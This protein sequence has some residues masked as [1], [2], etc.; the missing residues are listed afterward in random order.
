MKIISKIFFIVILLG[1]VCL[2]TTCS[3]E[4]WL[5][6]VTFKGYVYDSL[7]GKPVEGIWVG[8]RACESGDQ[9]NECQMYQVGQAKTDA[10]GYFYIHDNAARSNRY[11]PV[12]HDIILDGNVNTAGSALSTSYKYIYLN[13]I[14]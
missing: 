13:K 5:F 10:S 11:T 14:P 6:N 9:G 2:N 3:D 7:G 4:R 8:L 1:I 12:V